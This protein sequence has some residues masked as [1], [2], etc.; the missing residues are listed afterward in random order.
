MANLGR[1][2]QHYL[3]V[4]DWQQAIVPAGNESIVPLL[5]ES[6]GA[7]ALLVY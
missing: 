2:Q 6:R 7:Y 3:V 5:F 1:T 4:W